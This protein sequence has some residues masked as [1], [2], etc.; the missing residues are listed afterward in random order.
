M[1]KADLLDNTE[2]GGE[3]AVPNDVVVALEDSN[4]KDEEADTEV[5]PGLHNLD[6]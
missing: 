5:E 2:E 4:T 6:Q 1:P 3:E